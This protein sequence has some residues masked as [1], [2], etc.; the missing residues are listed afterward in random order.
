[1]KTDRLPC[2]HRRDPLSP[3]SCAFCKVASQTKRLSIATRSGK[4]YAKL[5]GIGRQCA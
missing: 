4:K 2:G 5:H 3:N 1:M